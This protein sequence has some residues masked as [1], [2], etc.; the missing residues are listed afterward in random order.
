MKVVYRMFAT[1]EN[2]RS[3]VRIFKP[4][5]DINTI[6]YFMRHYCME[7]A[8]NTTVELIQYVDGKATKCI[9]RVHKK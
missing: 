4:E 3:C 5:H 8:H 7:S 1:E 2:H 9:Y 6:K